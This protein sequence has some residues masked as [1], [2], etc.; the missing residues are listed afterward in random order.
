MFCKNCGKVL[1]QGELFCTN[2][3]VKAENENNIFGGNTLN[4][5]IS[6]QTMSNVNNLDNSVNVEQQTF[7]QPFVDN[8]ATINNVYQQPQKNFQSIIQNHQ[9]LNTDID[10]ELKKAYIGK[11][12]EKILKGHGGSAWLF[13]FGS[14]YLLYRKLY[15]YGFLYFLISLLLSYF[16]LFYVAFIIQIVLCFL[17]YKIYLNY[18]DKKVFYIKK[19][20]PNLSFDDLKEKCRKQG[21]VSY[22]MVA[23]SIGIWLI[24]GFIN[25]KIS[26]DKLVCTSNKGNI[27]I[28]YNE[29]RITGYIA[30]G[31]SYDLDAQKKYAKEIGIDAYIIEFDN[32]F[33]SNTSGYCTINGEK[34]SK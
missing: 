15:L 19:S 3:G 18:V 13:L 32:W 28:M 1:N 6:T 30:N 26:L 21:G 10:Q 8:N 14:T 27:T 7:A 11:N 33:K 17:F 22:A 31:M 29:E 16:N 5:N 23:L 9:D 2:C 25:Y 34:V 12:A 4:Q 24:F 20:N